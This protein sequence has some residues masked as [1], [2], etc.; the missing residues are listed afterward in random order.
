MFSIIA[1][2]FPKNMYE[3][4]KTS[5]WRTTHYYLIINYHFDVFS[6][7]FFTDG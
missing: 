1:S 6:F 4:G 7:L 3:A 2:G 5:G